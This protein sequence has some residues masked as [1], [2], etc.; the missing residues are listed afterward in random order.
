M[1]APPALI[2]WPS[3]APDRM[4]DL[5]I[6]YDQLDDE[7]SQA[8]ERWRQEAGERL[9]AQ[10]RFDALHAYFHARDRASGWPDWPEEYRDPAS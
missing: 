8:F 1:A 2:D 4:R 7:Q 6:V 3:A 10:A 9:E 5:R